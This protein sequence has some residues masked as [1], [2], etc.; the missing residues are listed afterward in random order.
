MKSSLPGIGF[1]SPGWPRGVC[2]NGI[3]TYVANAY[4]A[5]RKLGV[6]VYILSE[7]T[8]FGFWPPNIKTLKHEDYTKIV[9]VI[10]AQ[11]KQLKKEGKIDIF[12]MEETFGWAHSVAQGIP[13]PLVVKLHGPWFLNGRADG[14]LEDASFIQRIKDEFKGMQSAA[15][16][17]APSQ[18]V[19]KRTQEYYGVTFKNARVIPNP[20][21]IIPEKNGGS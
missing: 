20:T 9:E 14:F 21:R 2:A 12:E 7:K 6:A 18:D 13:V 8:Q 19:L 17:T 3:E 1:L 5:L 11:V 16:V 4:Y 10:V 15:G